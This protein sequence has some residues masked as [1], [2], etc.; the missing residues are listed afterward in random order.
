MP[1]VVMQQAY[2][3][4]DWYQ[5]LEVSIGFGL[6]PM[7]QSSQKNQAFF[8]QGLLF[9]CKKA[10]FELTIGILAEKKRHFLCE[11]GGVVEG[12]ASNSKQPRWSSQLVFTVAYHSF[13]IL[14]FE[15]RGKS[16]MKNAVYVLCGF[17]CEYLM[18]LFIEM[19]VA[20][21]AYVTVPAVVIFR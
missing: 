10:V 13:Y 4:S 7:Q 17:L 21:V 11:D 8:L 9:L 5:G 19:I 6:M 2:C 12:E 18:R 3:V 14:F 16:H 20:G 15:D 1:A